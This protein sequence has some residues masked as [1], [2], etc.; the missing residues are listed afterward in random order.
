MDKVKVYFAHPIVGISE[1][2]RRR[3]ERIKDKLELAGFDVY[4]P[5]KMKVENA[6]GM[7]M[8]EWG[9]CVFDNDMKQIRSADWVVCCDHGR[10]ST[11]GTAFEM[12]FAYG[13][14]KHIW[15]ID[16]SQKKDFSLMTY[17]GCHYRVHYSSFLDFDKEWLRTHWMMNAYEMFNVDK[18]NQ[19]TLN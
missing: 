15:S 1:E 16:M 18:Y 9:A 11:G 8:R 2:N 3:H 13:I 4:D 5:A 14:K 10:Q 6:N 19:F 12:G 7:T 17:F